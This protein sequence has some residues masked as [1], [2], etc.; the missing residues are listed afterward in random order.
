MAADHP[1]RRT[2]PTSIILTDEQ[3]ADLRLLADKKLSTISQVTRELVQEGLARHTD[4]RDERADA[5]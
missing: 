1:S 3:H 2:R 4:K 5:R